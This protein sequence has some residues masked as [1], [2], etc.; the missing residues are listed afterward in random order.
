[1]IDITNTPLSVD[2]NTNLSY[3]GAFSQYEIT[4]T[5]YK[6]HICSRC[7]NKDKNF[8]YDSELC[9]RCDLEN[10]L[11]KEEKSPLKKIPSEEFSKMDLYRLM[12]LDLDDISS[13]T[14]NKQISS[15]IKDKNPKTT[16]SFDLV[17][18]LQ[19]SKNSNV[20]VSPS[21][22]M[23]TLILLSLGSS[24][25]TKQQL[26]NLFDKIDISIP[27]NLLSI[28]P[29]TIEA[30][31]SLLP[32]YLAHIKEENKQSW[33]TSIINTVL[34]P[35]DETA[36]LDNF[37]A[38]LT[39][40]GLPLSENMKKK[41]TVLKAV[42][43]DQILSNDTFIKDINEIFAIKTEDNVQE[44]VRQGDFSGT[45][46]AILNAIHFYGKWKS[47]FTLD[48]YDM[49]FSSSAHNSITVKSMS[50]KT[51][52]Y[53]MASLGDWQA[54]RLFGGDSKMLI[55]YIKTFLFTF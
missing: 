7:D 9:T 6:K 25:T 37:N 22:V 46:I 42:S 20:I 49:P 19:E 28:R 40:A 39:D 51:T 33:L 32:N 48:D 2:N 24:G 34:S 55:C 41:L 29:D 53:Q 17:K 15:N 47:A 8:V 26:F 18:L 35:A 44:I 11:L 43:G 45:E 23:R 31:D 27:E 12:L 1:M 5:E 3:T 36:R 4:I 52:N 14:A 38:V 30:N 13:L 21:S 16:F 54:I 10:M 50:L